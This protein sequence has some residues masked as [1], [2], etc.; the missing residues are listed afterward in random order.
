VKRLAERS[1]DHSIEACRAVAGSS[2]RQCRQDPP[3]RVDVCDGALLYRRAFLRA[4]G[5]AYAASGANSIG[6]TIEGSSF[7]GLLTRV[8]IDNKG[9]S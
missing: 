9:S 6:S 7:S 4:I 3:Q 1:V 8:E 5:S 2:S